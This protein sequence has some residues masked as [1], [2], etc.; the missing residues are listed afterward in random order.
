M[1]SI[2]LCH[3]IPIY[4]HV[5][6]SSLLGVSNGLSFVSEIRQK[7]VQ[8]AQNFCLYLS[9]WRY[10]SMSVCWFMWSY[11]NKNQRWAKNCNKEDTIFNKTRMK[12]LSAFKAAYK[13]DSFLQKSEEVRIDYKFLQFA[14]SE[15]SIRMIFSHFKEQ[16]FCKI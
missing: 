13:V 1:K 11:P 12:R 16:N 2:R 6:K 7:V 3:A 15:Y 9:V 5:A 14:R 10:M 4:I 8:I